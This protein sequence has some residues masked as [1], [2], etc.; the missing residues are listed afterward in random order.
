MADMTFGCYAICSKNQPVATDVL[1][2]A[3]PKFVRMLEVKL[4]RQLPSFSYIGT[5]GREH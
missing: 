5:L 1:Y 4:L 2:Q 3:M